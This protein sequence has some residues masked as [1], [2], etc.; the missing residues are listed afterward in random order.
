MLPW[1]SMQFQDGVNE[2]LIKSYQTFKRLF[3]LLCTL[4]NGGFVFREQGD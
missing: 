2:T 1:K 3:Y 4:V